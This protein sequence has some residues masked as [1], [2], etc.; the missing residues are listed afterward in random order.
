[1]TPIESTSLSFCGQAAHA[2]K[3]EEKI[4]QVAGFKR[5]LK[6]GSAFSA[7][8]RPALNSGKKLLLDSIHESKTAEAPV[9][10][11]IVLKHFSTKSGIKAHLV[12][13]FAKQKLAY[14]SSVEEL[15]AAQDLFYSNPTH[16]NLH[17]FHTSQ[18]TH[19]AIYESLYESFSRAYDYGCF[20]DLYDPDDVDLKMEESASGESS[21]VSK[22][23]DL[24]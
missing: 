5:T 20:P 10:D 17:R 24:D 2:E 19:D 16:K 6:L 3:N 7:F 13:E 8:H 22:L 1:M 15:K 11:A 14:F 21:A 4:E 12:S 18:K 23:E 9:I